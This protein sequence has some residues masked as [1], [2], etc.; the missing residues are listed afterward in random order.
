MIARG[1]LIKK[2]SEIIQLVTMKHP[3]YIHAYLQTLLVGTHHKVGSRRNVAITCHNKIIKM[4]TVL[5][6]D[7]NLK[8]RS[9]V[10][11]FC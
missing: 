11:L 7:A 3:E 6:L 1:I 2:N 4:K 10:K 5:I 9:S 8:Y